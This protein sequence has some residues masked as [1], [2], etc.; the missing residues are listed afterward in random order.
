MQDVDTLV[1]QE[2]QLKARVHEMPDGRY[3]GLVEVGVRDARGIHSKLHHCSLLRATWSDAIEDAEKLLDSIK[4]NECTDAVCNV[5]SARGS[6]AFDTFMALVSSRT[7]VAPKLVS[8]TGSKKPAR[9]Q[10]IKLAAVP[11]A[12]EKVVALQR[13]A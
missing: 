13:H 1:V 8:S 12:D 11:A 3:R 2:Y 4:A 5:F 10:A 9:R 7:P 6:T